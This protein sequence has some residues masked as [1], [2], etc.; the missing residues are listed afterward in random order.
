VTDLA[1]IARLV[2]LVAS[3]EA[4]ALTG[5]TLSADGGIWMAP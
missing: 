1:G 2:S 5:A 3:G 4:G